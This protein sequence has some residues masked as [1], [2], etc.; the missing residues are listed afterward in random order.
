MLLKDKI[1]IVT[2]AGRGIGAGIA[3]RYAK[4]GAKVVLVDLQDDDMKNVVTQINESG[5]TAVGMVANVAVKSDLMNVIEK[6]VGLFGTIDIL[7]NNAG[8][9]RDGKAYKMKE[10]AWDTVI[11]VNLKGPFLACQSVLPVMMEKGYGK[12]VNIASTSR[13]G[14]YGQSNYSA[15]KEG[16][17]GLTRALAKEVGVNGINV[18]AVAP[19][20]TATE[21]FLALPEGAKEAAKNLNPMFRVG[22][23]EGVAAACAFL[24]SDDA[25][26]ITGQCLQVDGGMFMP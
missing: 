6:A 14:N 25:S 1:A 9:T 17:V 15:S 7:V 11:S 23:V 13:F 20:A 5:G 3:R 16:L 4:E 21:M 8:I 2:G 18:N 10:E 24:A 12:I 19:G 22:T 26:F